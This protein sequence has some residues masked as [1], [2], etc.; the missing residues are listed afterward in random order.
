MYRR[1]YVVYI[2]AYEQLPAL[3][4]V[5]LPF[6]T[7]YRMLGTTSTRPAS[8]RSVRE[9]MRHV[10]LRLVMP[11]PGP[12]SWFMGEM[13]PAVHGDADQPATAAAPT[14]LFYLHVT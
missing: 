5:H 9:T 6:L 12:V 1:V 3:H 14:E 8:E 2:F 7:T 10:R 13:D 4:N 11:G